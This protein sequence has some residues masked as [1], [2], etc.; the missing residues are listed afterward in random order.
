CNCLCP[1]VAQRPKQPILLSKHL[2]R[3]HRSGACSRQFGCPTDPYLLLR[4]LPAQAQS[5]HT[6]FALSQRLL[7]GRSWPCGRLWDHTSL[8][9]AQALQLLRPPRLRA[10][11]ETRPP[12]FQQSRLVKNKNKT[13][14]ILIKQR[15]SFATHRAAVLG[16]VAQQNLA[17]VLSV[18]CSR[19]C[20]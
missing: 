9:H 3:S 13:K 11:P 12:T 8:T 20:G 7:L 1:A 17:L 6:A 2:L 14:R 15:H 16:N 19:P 5:P 4:A 10:T 18:P